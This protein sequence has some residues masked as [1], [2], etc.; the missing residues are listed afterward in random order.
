MAA[1]RTF[2]GLGPP[3][4]LPERVRSLNR[5]RGLTAALLRP[6]RIVADGA[7]A[8]VLA[9]TV[10]T[11]VFDIRPTV[12]RDPVAGTP[13][14]LPRALARAR[15]PALTAELAYPAS[16][17]MAARRV[18]AMRPASGVRPVNSRKAPTA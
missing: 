3:L 15:P 5:D 11:E 9:E 6:G 2:L 1:P 16:A 14:C 18:A 13:V 4:T 12:L 8:G 17:A 10:P 7:P